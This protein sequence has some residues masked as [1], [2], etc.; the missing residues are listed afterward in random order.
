MH[1][2][3]RQ[4]FYTENGFLV[5]KNFIPIEACQ[6]LM[7]RMSQLIA[8]FNPDHIKTI[9]STKNQ[10]PTLQDYFLESGDKI[11]FFFEENAFL[12]NG[13]LKFEKALSI[14]KIGHALHDLDSI[15]YCFSRLHKI[16]MLADELG[17]ID[18]LIVQSMY[19][20]KQPLIG[21]EVTCHQDSTFLY[22]KEKPVVGF[23]FAL[24]EA[25]LENGCLWVIP[26]GHRTPPK[27]RLI[28]KDQTIKTEQYDDSPWDLTQMIPLEVPRGSLIVLHG[29]LPHMSKENVSPKSRHAYSLHLLSRDSEFSD[30]NWL[31]R[32]AHLPFKGFVD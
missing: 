7:N 22:A 11:R 32:G 24:E 2:S 21:G 20:C 9:F 12:P 6:L 3:E 5:L 15:F 28:C 17:L 26:G 23:W 10:R 25:T 18:P 8:E 19:I 31:K 30:E 1:T 14:N 4:E 16:A 29:D 13:D 27:L